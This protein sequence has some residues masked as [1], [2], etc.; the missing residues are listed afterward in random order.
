M[1]DSA[2]PQR[3]TLGA[4]TFSPARFLSAIKES[5]VWSALNTNEQFQMTT[6]FRAMERLAER[7]GTEGSPTAPLMQAF[8]AIKSMFTI[9]PVAMA[10]GAAAM[11]AP[12]KASDALLTPEGR[13]AIVQ[14]ST[15]N[16]GTKNFVAAATYLGAIGKKND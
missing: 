15:T 1:P 16:P 2:A 8:D 7:A 14:L 10:S 6:A 9:N 11:V 12:R 4:D 5:P 3:Q 13:R